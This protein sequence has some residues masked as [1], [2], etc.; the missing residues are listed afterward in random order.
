MIKRNIYRG[1]FN[2]TAKDI[3]IDY[4]INGILDLVH[5]FFADYFE[6]VCLRGGEEV[7]GV[8]ILIPIVP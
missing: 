4:S 7:K 8:K 6:A 3:L 1:V 5:D 2:Y